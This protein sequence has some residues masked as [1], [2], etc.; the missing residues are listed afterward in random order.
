[1]I[2]TWLLHKRLHGLYFWRTGYGI[3]FLNWSL[4]LCISLCF[5]ERPTHPS[6]GHVKPPRGD[7]AAQTTII[8]RKNTNTIYLMDQY[9]NVYTL[10]LVRKLNKFYIWQGLKEHRMWQWLWYF[11]KKNG[12]VT[13]VSPNLKRVFCEI[14]KTLLFFSS[15]NTGTSYVIL[16]A[17]ET[18]Y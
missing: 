18:L 2:F 5:V 10:V 11:L 6:P 12:Q 9:L 7:L 14:L 13:P 1:M 4:F 3:W 17:L 8:F 16:W 15:P